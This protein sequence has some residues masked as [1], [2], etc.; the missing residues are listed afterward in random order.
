[1]SKSDLLDPTSSDAAVKQAIAETSIIHE[2]KEYFTANG[3]DLDAF[4]SNKRGDTSVLV[5]NFPYPTSAEELRQLFGEHGTILQV[6][7]PPSG[8]IAIVQ[9]AQATHAKTA[10]ARLAYRR[11]RDSV[12]KLEPGPR[13]LF[14]RQKQ[15]SQDE[16]EQQPAA[17]VQKPSARELL[18]KEDDDHIE[19]SS[20]FVRNLNFA[21]TTAELADAFKSLD[22]FVSAQV[23]TKRDVKKPGQVLSMGFGFVHFRSKEQAEAALKT[24]D[25]Y[26]LQAHTLAVKASHRGLDAAEERKRDEQAKK[27]TGHGTKIVIKNLPFEASKKD[28][29][30]LFGNYGQLRGVRIPQKFG[31]SRGFAFA[32]FASRKDAENALNALRSTHLL[33]RR[34]VLD[35]A[36]ADAVDPEEE[37]AKMAK[38]IG[39]QVNK[40]TLQQLTGRERKKV[41][42]GGNED[43]A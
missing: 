35:F 29:R 40:V 33:G 20:L 39:G 25:G 43:E 23:K 10:L 32:D 1:M 18:E 26:V 8:T 27:A 41:N 14:V 28:V 34:L 4:K 9:F 19:T 24:M 11:F 2:A 3:V 15:V 21:T 37:I 38:K 7:M 30:A 31:G 22:G 6:L 16:G 42:I 36:E 13:D 5:K 17:G 12:L